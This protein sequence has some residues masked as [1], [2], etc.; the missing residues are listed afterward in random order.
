MQQWGAK[1]RLYGIAVF[2][3]HPGK[4][5]ERGIDLEGGKRGSIADFT[6]VP[7]GWLKTKLKY[8]ALWS[9]TNKVKA[10]RR[11]GSG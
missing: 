9:F 10:L 4:F 1:Y 6:E 3:K 11:R 2:I 7:D 8:H 5:E